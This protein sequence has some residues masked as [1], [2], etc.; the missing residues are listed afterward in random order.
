MEL[1]YANMW[2]VREEWPPH[3][4]LL[5]SSIHSSH[6][7]QVVQETTWQTAA[8]RIHGAAVYFIS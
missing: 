5:S 6:Q 8:L 7:N 3:T 4:S 1:A 2:V